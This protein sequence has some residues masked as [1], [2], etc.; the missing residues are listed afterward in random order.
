MPK[1]DKKEIEELIRRQMLCRIAFKGTNYPYIAPFHYVYMNGTL[2][3]HFTD[4]GKKM[5]LIGKDRHV[6]VEIEEFQ[7]KLSQYNF[8]ALRGSLRVVTDPEERAGAIA[9][10][11]REG[12]RKLSPNF[13]AAHRFEKHE[14]WSSLSAD[15][16]IVIIKLVDIVEEIGIRSP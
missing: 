15:K 5:K 6:C 1:M 2:Y 12:E 7:P 8:V 10:M 11:A 13:L 14:G 4:Y 3:F 9:R 16:P